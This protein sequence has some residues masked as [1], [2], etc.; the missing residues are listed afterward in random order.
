MPSSKALLRNLYTNHYWRTVDHYCDDCS[1]VCLFVQEYESQ[2]SQE[3][4]VVKE[5]DQLEMVLQA[6]EY[7]EL[8]GNPG[9]LQEFFNSTEGCITFHVNHALDSWFGF[10]F[11]SA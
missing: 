1:P 10:F 9:R 8:E 7:E 3:A 2:S 5:L 11:F 4:R 6:H